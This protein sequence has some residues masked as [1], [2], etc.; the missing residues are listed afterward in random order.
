MEIEISNEQHEELC[1]KLINR[2]QLIKL[3]IKCLD[4]KYD[5]N[6]Q[7]IIESIT[8][9]KKITLYSYYTKPIHS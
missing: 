5:A 4:K 2:N 6:L 9:N 1:L 7:K 8:C 3:T